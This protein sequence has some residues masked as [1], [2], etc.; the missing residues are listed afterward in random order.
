MTFAV[1]GVP[2][3]EKKTFG[4]LGLGNGSRFNDFSLRIALFC[5]ISVL[6]ALSVQM[7]FLR[8]IFCRS[9]EWNV[10]DRVVPLIARSISSQIERSMITRRFSLRM[11][12]L[13]TCLNVFNYPLYDVNRQRLDCIQ[14]AA[15]YREKACP[16]HVGTDHFSITTTNG[17][18]DHT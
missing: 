8:S 16:G 4:T 9:L 10:A 17:G 3:S 14:D 7:L 12:R 18:T 1:T 13:L 2:P 15:H 6:Q 5:N 11:R